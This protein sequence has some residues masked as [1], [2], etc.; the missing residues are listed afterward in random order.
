[1]IELARVLEHRLVA[2][3]PDL[4][5]NRRRRV[6]DALVL[7]ILECEQVGQP[8]IEAG[9]AGRQACNPDHVPLFATAPAK[10]SSSGW[11][12]PRLSLSAAWFTIRRAL[13]G[14]ISSTAWRPLARSVLPLETR[15]TIASARPTSGA[16]S[17][18]P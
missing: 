12:V 3:R 6:F 15:S 8:R 14:M 1:M 18:E 7:G 13:I 2:A 11:I 17:I 10:A 16:S 9:V 4:A 5:Q